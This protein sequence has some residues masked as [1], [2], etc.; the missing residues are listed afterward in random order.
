M[1]RCFDCIDKGNATKMTGEMLMLL[2]F[3]QDVRVNISEYVAGDGGMSTFLLGVLAGMD[4]GTDYFGGPVDKIVKSDIVASMCQKYHKSFIK[5]VIVKNDI[6]LQRVV[7]GVLEEP[8][9]ATQDEVQKYK[10]MCLKSMARVN[11]IE[12]K[13]QMQMKHM[14]EQDTSLLHVK[15]GMLGD[16]HLREMAYDILHGSG[17]EN[18]NHRPKLAL[19]CIGVGE[20]EVESEGGGSCRFGWEETRGLLIAQKVSLLACVLWMWWTRP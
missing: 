4:A 7:L 16:D 6:I 9:K 5:D 20:D 18:K 17:K 1:R 13:E 15:L 3:P 11:S 8:L 10:A 19:R 2:D 12:M 14:L